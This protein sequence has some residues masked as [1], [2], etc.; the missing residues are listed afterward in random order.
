LFEAGGDRLCD[1]TV[2]VLSDRAL[3][4]AR[5]RARDALPEDEISRRLDAQLPDAFFRERCDFILENNGT[6][7]DLEAACEDLL[8]RIGVP[9]PDRRDL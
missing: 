4:V 8:S 3:R 5:L 6:T 2:G 1:C 7:E 9:C